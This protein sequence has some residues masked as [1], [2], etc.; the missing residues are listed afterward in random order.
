MEMD[1]HILFIDAIIYEAELAQ[2]QI[3]KMWCRK[4]KMCQTP[5][6]V[7]SLRIQIRNLHFL[8]CLKVCQQKEI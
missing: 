8:F 4:M 2:G 5:K 7:V 3:D 6:L 1:V